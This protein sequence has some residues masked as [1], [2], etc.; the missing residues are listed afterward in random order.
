MNEKWKDIAT[1]KGLY[2][3]SNF[4][5]IKSISRTVKRRNGSNGSAYRTV[6]ERVLVQADNGYTQK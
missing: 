4:G 5:L 1:Y 6:R 3:V 2:K